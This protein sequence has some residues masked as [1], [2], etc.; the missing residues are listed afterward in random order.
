MAIRVACAVL[1]GW[2]LLV[3]S[4]GFLP[5]V[6]FPTGT[7]DFTAGKVQAGV[8]GL[9]GWTLSSG[10]SLSLDAN[11][12]RGV[13]SSDG[14]YEWQIGSQAAFQIPL[15]RDWAISG[16]GFISA[17]L[18]DHAT[19]PWGL[20]GGVEFYPNPETQL[21]LTLVQTFTEPGTATA[22]QLGFSRRFHP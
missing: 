19:A 21:D 16:D 18:V 15:R 7:S 22:I 20:D 1:A 12:T 6:S 14:P 2:T 13:E 4:V 5:S 9:L 17:P 11:L 8:S 3:P 10:T